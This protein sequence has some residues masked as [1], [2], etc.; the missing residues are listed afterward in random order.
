MAGTGRIVPV[1]ARTGLVALVVVGDIGRIG[2][3]RSQQVAGTFA[4]SREAGT[5]R[6]TE[7]AAA[8]QLLASMSAGFKLALNSCE[9]TGMRG[10]WAEE[11]SRGSLC[12]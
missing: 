3:G 10:H 9:S 4:G 8:L 7:E 6:R 12:S 2:S 1:E 5:E 11:D